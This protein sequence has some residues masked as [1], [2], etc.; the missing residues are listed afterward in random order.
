MIE[1]GVGIMMIFGAGCG[2]VDVMESRSE[3]LG[4]LDTCLT[5]IPR[6]ENHLNTTLLT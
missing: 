1:E 2:T 3:Y 4:N 5:E 6:P